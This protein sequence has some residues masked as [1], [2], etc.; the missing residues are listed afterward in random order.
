MNYVNHVSF[1]K[2][3]FCFCFR[4]FS[5]EPKSCI[6]SIILH[7]RGRKILLNVNSI[8]NGMNSLK[9]LDIESFQIIKSLPE[10]HVEYPQSF[11]ISP[12]GTYLY[13][14]LDNISI[15]VQ[16]MLTPSDSNENLIQGAFRNHSKNYVSNIDFHPKDSYLCCC[17][18]GPNGGVSIYEHASLPIP[19][20]STHKPLPSISSWENRK[21]LRDIIQRIDDVFLYPRLEQSQSSFEKV[22]QEV[23]NVSNSKVRER[24]VEDIVQ[25]I[26]SLSFDEASELS[27]HESTQEPL[28]VKEASQLEI[29]EQHVTSSNSSSSSD[30]ECR[31]F[32]I[33]KSMEKSEKEKS[34]SE[35]LNRTFSIEENIVTI[36]GN[37]YELERNRLSDDA[38]SVSDA[39]E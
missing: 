36:N 2:Y 4:T 10:K 8:G 34:E 20:Y 19:E 1:I 16:N 23:Q 13:I 6:S 37:T 38:T 35:K 27:R 15:E 9:F 3:Y 14:S 5:V 28:T 39:F 11:A 31:T 32:S 30:N 7:P 21:K 33:H 29:K 24:V 12:C 17:V 26:P 25:E 18:Y 22:V